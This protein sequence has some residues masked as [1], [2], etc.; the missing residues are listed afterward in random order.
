[1]TSWRF[2]IRVVGSD[3]IMLGFMNYRVLGSEM[4]ETRVKKLR[5]VSVY[6]KG[7]YSVFKKFQFI[8][9]LIHCVLH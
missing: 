8:S 5:R 7:G 6:E 9:Q 1:M 3:M 2:G 4:R